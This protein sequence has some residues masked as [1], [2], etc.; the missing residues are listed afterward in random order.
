MNRRILV[1]SLLSLCFIFILLW[2]KFI[3]SYLSPTIVVHPDVMI[4]EGW[5]PDQTLDE[6]VQAFWRDHYRYIITTGFPETKGFCMGSQGKFI[7]DVHEAEIK[8]GKKLVSRD[9]DMINVDVTMRGT[10]VRNE[11]A[12]FKLFADS[13][14][15]GEAFTNKNLQT[16]SFRFKI[17]FNISEIAIVFDNDTYSA[18]RD[19]NLYIYSLSVNGNTFSVNNEVF[20]YYRHLSGQYVLYR[21]PGIALAHEAAYRL[22]QKGIPDSVIIPIG[23]FKKSKSKTY[24]TALDVL[25][26]LE[27]HSENHVKSLTIFTSGVH[28]GRSYLSFCKVFKHSNINIGVVSCIDNDIN[29]HNWWKSFS[30]IREII[31]ETAGILYIMLVG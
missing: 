28:A 7:F 20:K 21:Q 2:A 10:K 5:N 17:K 19:R 1:L 15:I 27:T 13:T 9:S 24:T 3:Y 25:K 26:W 30:R 4:V 12:H 23:S 14:F 11:Y 18:F 31:Y 8:T 29:E 22:I 16:F 6:A